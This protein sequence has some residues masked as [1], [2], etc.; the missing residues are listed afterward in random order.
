MNLPEKF[1]DVLKHE[2]V[3]SI[4]SWGVGDE[5]HVANTWNSYVVVTT[6]G[7][8]LIPAAGLNRTEKNVN[9]TGR[10]KVALG[11]REVAGYKDYQGTGFAVE[12]S[13]KFLASGPDFDMMKA[14][15]AF[16]TRVLEVAVTSAKQ[17]L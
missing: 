10:V 2:G 17:L 7:R 16:L 15:Y 1:H 4:V 9:H 6:D 13:A 3:V 5:P 12:G 8:M 11:S 14:K